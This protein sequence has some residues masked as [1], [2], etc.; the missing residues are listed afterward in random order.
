MKSLPLAAALLAAASA[1]FA[2]DTPAPA[3]VKRA[4]AIEPRKFA[5][6]K[7]VDPYWGVTYEFPGLE[8]KKAEQRAGIL[9]SGRAGRVQVEIG[10]WEH[11]DELTARER[12]ETETKKWMEKKRPMEDFAQGEDP[13]VWATW[14]GEAPSGGKRF[15]G[16]SWQTR[17]CRAFVVHAY[18]LLDVEKGAET[19]KAALLP[20]SVGP[21]TGAAIHAQMQ[22][23]QKQLPYDDPEVLADAAGAYNL[24]PAKHPDARPAIAEALYLASIER[25]PGSRFAADRPETR[26][27]VFNIHNFLAQAQINLKK[28]DAALP[29]LAKCAELAAKTDRPGPNGAV[30]QFNLA[31]C[32]S[33]AG[34]LDEAF[35]AL[36]KA[37][38]KPDWLPQVTMQ[39]LRDEPDLENCRRDPRWQKSVESRGLK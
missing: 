22:A 14:I 10:V 2:E 1:S 6:G 35:A 37:L 8:E 15:E 3:P 30:V 5:D 34:R 13:V 21:E 26:Q 7:L 29:T 4:K 11:P 17:G 24:D 19:V 25:I 33:S 31:C 32:Q 9:F 12:R 18:A 20:L 39:A 36:E 28:Y 23:K 16:R 38:E 27:T